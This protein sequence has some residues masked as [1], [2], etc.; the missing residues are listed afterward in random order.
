MTVLHEY[1]GPTGLRASP[2]GQ[3]YWTDDSPTGL[4]RSYMIPFMSY[5]IDLQDYFGPIGFLSSPTGQSYRTYRNPA[6]SIGFL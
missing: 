6:G 2:I 4:F 3:I 5:R 1:F